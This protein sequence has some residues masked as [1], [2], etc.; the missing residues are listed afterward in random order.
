MRSTAELASGGC[1][2][3]RVPI[4]MQTK[5]HNRKTTNYLGGRYTPPN[6]TSRI[7]LQQQQQ[8]HR[9]LQATSTSTKTHNS[10]KKLVSLRSKLELS[11][12]FLNIKTSE[13]KKKLEKIPVCSRAREHQLLLKISQ[14]INH[15]HA[16]CKRTDNEELRERDRERARGQ[17]AR[18]RR[19]RERE[20]ERTKRSKRVKT[21]Y[22]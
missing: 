8:Q 2:T 9:E 15:Q 14:R 11:T 4:S 21:I 20:R 5:V 10:T 13:G 17:S 3:L 6:K 12:N 1:T 7:N 16:T 18:A 19:E 22:Y